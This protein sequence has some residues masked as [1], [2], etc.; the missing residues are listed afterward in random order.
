MTTLT[1]RSSSNDY[2]VNIGA[3]LRHQLSDLLKNNYSKVLVITDSS[4]APLYLKDVVAAFGSDTVV[5]SEIV[6]AGEQ[7]KS[8]I[9][10]SGLLDR[11][12]ED[13][14]D[15]SS[16]IIA[17]GGGVIGDLAGFVA[18]TYLRGIDFL[19]MPTT[20]LAHDSSVGGKVAINHDKGKNLIGSFYSPVQVIYDTETITTLSIQEVRSG[21]GEVVKH[22]LLSDSKWFQHLMDTSL[23]SIEE[24][25]LIDH[26]TSGI[27]VKAQIVESDERETG[28]RKHLNLGHTLAHALEAE[29]GYGEVTH[30]EAVA[31][32][33]LFAMKI[34]QVKL[35]AKLPYSQYQKWLDDNN[36]PLHLLA[37]ID[38]EATLK[39]MKL[40]KKTL[41]NSIHYVLLNEVG[42]PTVIKLTDQEL[43]QS[44]NDFVQKEG[45]RIVDQ[46][47]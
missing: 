25:D 43:I 22:A 37:R 17:L 11:C 39:R 23:E 9:C 47:S 46:R 20:I 12:L 31:I 14:L 44:L 21:Y 30:G 3:G 13:Q 19:Q 32:G 6:P 1:I 10:Y 41:E 7:S 5:S 36:Y 26:L 2:Q 29:F 16:L 28:V 35:A 40:D 34:S 42:S 33:M 4:V 15:R 8:V 27:R 38:V 18:A 24:D 45:G